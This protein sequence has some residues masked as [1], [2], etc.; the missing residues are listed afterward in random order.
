[1]KG[2]GLRKGRRNNDKMNAIDF[3][4]GGG[5]MTRGL[6]SAGINVLFGLDSNPHCKETYENNNHIPYLIRNILEVTAA[7]LIEEFPI[8]H[9][10]DQLLMV[11]CAPCQPF[12]ILNPKDANEHVSV[13]LLNEFGRLVQGIHPA[14]ILVENVPGI[15]GK[16]EAVLQRFLDMLDREGYVYDKDVI[17]AKNYGVPQNRRRFV[18]I[19]SRLFEPHIPPAT[20]G[21]GLLPYVTVFNAIHNYPQ[22]AAGEEN[23]EVPNH[24]A[25]GMSPIT[26]Q[27]IRATPHDGGGRLEWPEELMLKCHRN[28]TGHS[29]V[30]G[31]MF[32]NHVSPTLTVKCFSISNGR[33]GHP[34]QNRAIS[35]RE[36]AAIQT[37]TDDYVFVGSLQ[38]IG[39]QIGNA[40]PVLLAQRIGEYILN[41]HN[42]IMNNREE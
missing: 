4:C 20:H 9:D 37:F 5:G 27:R 18:L 2:N 41:E 38:E 10:N 36:A 8:L 31:R 1:M 26:M 25:A 11:G 14:H 23:F 17:N 34:E 12:S 28:F 22:L 16:G 21:D 29:D 40:V 32:W 39:K 6:I 19:A 15:K 13:N 42:E 7:E 35:L 33:F 3:F 30:Y 24:R